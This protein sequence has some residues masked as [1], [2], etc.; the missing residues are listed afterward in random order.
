M[1]PRND[2]NLA[3]QEDEFIRRDI[4]TETEEDYEEGC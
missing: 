3:I 2:D 4:S 1:S